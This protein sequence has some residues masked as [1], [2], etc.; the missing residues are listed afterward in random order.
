LY[1][2]FYLNRARE[3][4]MVVAQLAALGPLHTIAP[5]LSRHACEQL[6]GGEHERQQGAQAGLRRLDRRDTSYK[7]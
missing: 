3:I 4:Q 5:H 6:M 2:M 1:I 7:D